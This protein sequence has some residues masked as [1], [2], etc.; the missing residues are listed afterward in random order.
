MDNLK[1]LVKRVKGVTEPLYFCYIANEFSVQIFHITTI[2]SIILIMINISLQDAKRWIAMFSYYLLNLF[3]CSA[4][5]ESKQEQNSTCRNIYLIN[6]FILS[7]VAFLHCGIVPSIIIIFIII[8]FTL[9]Y[10]FISEDMRITTYFINKFNEK[11]IIRRLLMNFPFF[12]NYVFEVL[13]YLFFIYLLMSSVLEF[14]IKII[15]LIIYILSIPILNKL[16]DNAGI[17]IVQLFE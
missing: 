16:A 5:K 2:I 8:L 15:I 14:K 17:D 1:K 9:L 4:I 3:I 7:I 6:N 10:Y 12:L 13:S 11:N